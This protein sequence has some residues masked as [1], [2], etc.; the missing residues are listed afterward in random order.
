MLM[1]LRVYLKMHLNQE[2]KLYRSF[3]VYSDHAG[4]NVTRRS[5]NGMLVYF[6][7]APII[8]Y[9]KRQYM[10]EISTLSL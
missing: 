9:Y 7:S 4:D 8:F 1:L 5:H 6:S 10:V 2:G 3:F